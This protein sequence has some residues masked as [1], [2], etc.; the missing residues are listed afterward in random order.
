VAVKYGQPMRFEQ[1]R[2]EAK[3][4]S[5]PRLKEI[6]QQVANEIMAAIARL[7]PYEDKAQFP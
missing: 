7:E 5:K 3:V 2:A 1:L 6:Y 4:C